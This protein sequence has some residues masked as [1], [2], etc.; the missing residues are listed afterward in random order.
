LGCHRRQHGLGKAPEPFY[1]PLVFV[2]EECHKRGLELHAWFNPFRSSYAP[3]STPAPSHISVKRPELAKPYGRQQWMDPGEPDAR[4]HSLAV[5]MDVVKRY[6]VDGIHVDDYFY[7]Y[8][9]RGADGN[10]L[11]FPDEPSYAKY[12]TGGGK[13]ERDDWRRNNIN[14][15]IEAMY[16]G[17]KA[18][19][20]WVKVGISPF[21]I[22]RP[23]NPKGISGLD[24][25]AELYADSRKWLKSGWVDYFTPQL[26][27][28]SSRP[29]QSYPALLEWWTKQN[30]KHRNLW[31]GNILSHPAEEI[32]KQI[33][34]TRKQKG[35]TGNVFFSA[36]TLLRNRGGV[37]DELAKAYAAPALVPPSP[38]LEKDGPKAPTLAMDAGTATWTPESPAWLWVVRSCTNGTWITDILPAGETTR[39]VGEAD[40]FTVAAVDRCGLASAP[41][42]WRG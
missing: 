9:V 42:V 34:L 23:G 22:W 8:K 18:L 36:R 7:P 29:Q 12:K 11:D 15:F 4:A 14:Q 28:A 39:P 3:G 2:I 40:V 38:W 27:W 1:D 10:V 13:L 19:K 5:F 17:T 26:Y 24:P 6:D 32:A 31:P 21:G 33:D 30:S 16:K 20:P 25:F 35:A 41:A 37:T